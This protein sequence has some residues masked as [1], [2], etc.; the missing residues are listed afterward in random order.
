MYV[1]V[2]LAFRNCS[3]HSRG[4]SIR[5]VALVGKKGFNT[6]MIGR[7]EIAIVTRYENQYDTG[8]RRY[9]FNESVE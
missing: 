9:I 1:G 6:F 5:T 2:L 8:R 7:G 3:G 4:G